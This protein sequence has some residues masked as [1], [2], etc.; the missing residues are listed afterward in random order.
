M[1]FLATVRKISITKVY[2]LLF[3]L[4]NTIATK[5]FAS[6]D[7]TNLSTYFFYN[8]VPPIEENCCRQPSLNVNCLT[9]LRHSF[10]RP[11]LEKAEV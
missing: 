4:R 9:N 11:T 10:K 6:F 8:F 2:L 1:K 3:P 5:I 7:Q